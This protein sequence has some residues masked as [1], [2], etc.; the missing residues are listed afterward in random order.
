MNNTLLTNYL[1]FRL[2]NNTEIKINILRNQLFFQIHRA[3]L[4]MNGRAGISFPGYDK[5]QKSPLGNIIRVFGSNA[6]LANFLTNLSIVPIRDYI[7]VSGI[8]NTPDCC[9]YVSFSRIQPK[10]YSAMRRF[11][12]RN[13]DET[14]KQGFYDKEGYNN[15]VY[16]LPYI[17]YYSTS[18]KNYVR[19]FIKMGN[20][21]IESKN[22]GFSSF[23]LSKEGSTVPHF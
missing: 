6:D 5:N 2:L 9:Q 22:G 12:R 13:K 11:L 1:E 7:D 20:P 4:P 18:T 8:N 10:G 16:N 19:V 21:T 14:K 23:G 3:I 15:F 17:N